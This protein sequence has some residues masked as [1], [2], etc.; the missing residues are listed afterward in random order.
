VN[1]NYIGI[2]IRGWHRH[3]LLEI[4]HS[5][6]SF[7]EGMNAVRDIGDLIPIHDFQETPPLKAEGFTSL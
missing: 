5:S 2:V 3:Q 1:E 4:P 6:P 7:L